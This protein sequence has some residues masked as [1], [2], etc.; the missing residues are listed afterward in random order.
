MKYLGRQSEL[1]NERHSVFQIIK[2]Y[3]VFHSNVLPKINELMLK[4]NLQKCG[5]CS[6]NKA[7]SRLNYSADDGMEA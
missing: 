3:I 6:E 2:G 7:L 5:A 4:A 1:S